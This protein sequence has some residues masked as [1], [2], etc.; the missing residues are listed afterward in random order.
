MKN[1]A[2]LAVI[3]SF[4]FGTMAMAHEGHDAKPTPAAEPAK[5]APKKVIAKPEAEPKK[6]APEAGKKK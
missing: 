5:A 1:I 3:A 2:T 6:A 4:S